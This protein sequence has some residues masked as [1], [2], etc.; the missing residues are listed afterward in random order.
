VT[1]GIGREEN[2]TINYVDPGGT[3]PPVTAAWDPEKERV[4]SRHEQSVRRFCRSRM[5]NEAD[6][7]DAAQET[8]VRFLLYR[9]EVQKPEAWLI[10]AARCACTDLHRRNKSRQASELTDGIAS[11]SPDPQD[12]VVQIHAAS[13]LL[14]KLRQPD[15]DL[16][17]KLYM[18]GLSVQQVA[19]MLNVSPGNVRIM[20]MRARRRAAEVFADARESVGAFTLVPTAW[21][22]IG[23]TLNAL[24]R[25]LRI[26]PRWRS[27]P[28]TR[29]ESVLQ[30]AAAL[31]QAV[32][33]PLV[34]GALVV[35]P[36][37]PPHP[38]D[39]AS[40]SG[41]RIDRAAS[42]GQLQPIVGPGVG[43]SSGLVGAAPS[44]RA[45]A[46]TR[47]VDGSGG[48]L[49][50]NLTNPGANAKQQD[51]AFASM[52]ASPGY[53]TDHTVFASGTLLYGCAGNCSTL[54]KSTDAGRSWQRQTA[55][56]FLGGTIL[57][58]PSYPRD[59]TVFAV[60]SAGL[61]RSDDGAQ[62]FAAPLPGIPTAAV[63]PASP[64]GATRLL[65]GTAPLLWYSAAS[66]A[67]TPGPVL[68][69]TVTAV[70]SV[71][72]QPDGS[73][74]VSGY[75]R[76]LASTSGVDAAIARCSPT[77]IVEDV[78]RNEP[79]AAFAPS[80]TSTEIVALASDRVLLSRD[81]G[82]SFN[83]VTRVWSGTLIT[84]AA[85][86]RYLVMG[87]LDADRHSQVAHSADR[88]LTFTMAPV[89]ALSGP[90]HL[91]RIV[92]L[93]DGHWLGALAFP[94][95][96]GDFGIRCSSDLGATWRYSC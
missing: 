22:W 71:L 61:Q 7:E 46:S 30:T 75:Q 80:V 9:G 90:L 37:A 88:G 81:G 53:P 21:P 23:R 47:P 25:S 2:V 12:T 5:Q 91:E 65:I 38:V 29:S 24:Q 11:T 15:R 49:I 94:D 48:A 70:S 36:G 78:A 86:S 52:T 45:G 54:F 35:G 20:A 59:R 27:R 40:G 26:R 68:P 63:D 82:R 87:W 34:V 51:V 16:L 31:S 17:E 33:I 28:S 1:C 62:T 77:C 79:A 72:V 19:A 44:T 96:H 18:R 41:L 42:R 66:G 58:P 84:A 32:L 8:F 76:D 14:D 43:S 74:L 85:D 39:V 93:P 4:L 89:G 73:V 69:P 95:G 50:R 3:T 55:T 13:Q 92:I 60:G 57:L 67:L 56:G 83:P 6:A 64:A 10:N